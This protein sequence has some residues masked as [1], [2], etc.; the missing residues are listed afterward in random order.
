MEKED[1][2]PKE[3]EV[4]IGLTW[5]SAILVLFLIGVGMVISYLFF[6]K[7]VEVPTVVEKPI[8]ILNDSSFNCTKICEW[9]YP[10]QNGCQKCRVECVSNSLIG[11]CRFTTTWS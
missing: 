10:T 5:S 8:Y 4:Y 1:S 9:D 7:T 2:K 6:V 11:E 3:K